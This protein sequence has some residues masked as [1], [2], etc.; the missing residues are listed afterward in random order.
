MPELPE[1]ETMVRDLSRR[2]VGRRIVEVEASFPGIVRYPEFPEF[3]QRVVGRTIEAVSRRGKYAILSLFSG[4]SL[5]I[6]RGMSGS[7]L[8]RAPS[9]PEDRFVRLL[10]RL[11]DG[12]ELRY[13]DPR[14]FGKIFVM[15]GTGSERPLPWTNMGPE[16]LSDDFTVDGFGEA[17]S[18]RTALIKPLLLG[19]QI[20]AGLGNIYVDEALHLAGIHPERRANT[21]SPDEV[22]RLYA[23]IREVLAMAVERRGTT[24]SSYRDLEG[25]SGQY[26]DALQVFRKAGTA[27]PRC[28]TG[29][30]RLV[31]GGRGTH[32]CPACQKV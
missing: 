13:D 32:I 23:A 19:Q 7:L 28:G 14:K 20:V 24:F 3:V 30:I 8:G 21:L 27:C 31:V 2:V 5:I 15:E 29:I 16:P 1:V 6:H 26:Q 17:L 25:R 12:S 22:R 4:D 11:D 10:I 9:D 18:K